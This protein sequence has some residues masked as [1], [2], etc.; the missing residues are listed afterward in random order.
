MPI[1]KGE[2]YVET[3][4]LRND[5]TKWE[6]K[7]TA[8]HDALKEVSDA[9]SLVSEEKGNEAV[10]LARPLLDRRYIPFCEQGMDKFASI[11]GSLKDAAYD[12]ESTDEEIFS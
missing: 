12:Y 11:A 8:V 6:G 7:R 10:L 2:L 3:Q 1:S 5:A 4:A 9:L